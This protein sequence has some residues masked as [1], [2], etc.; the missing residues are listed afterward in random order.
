MKLLFALFILYGALC[1]FLGYE[2][3]DSVLTTGVV[4]LADSAE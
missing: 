3:E 1:L 2:G 4:I